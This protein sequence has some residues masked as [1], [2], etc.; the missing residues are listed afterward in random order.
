MFNNAFLRI[1]IGFPIAAAI[2]YSLFIF[3]GHLI[4]ADFVKPE[5]DEARTIERITPEQGGDDVQTRSR[6]K[7]Q[8]M[9]SANKPPPPPKITASKSDV[10]LPSA[11][12]QGAAPAEL[13]FERVQSIDIVTVVII[14]RDAQPISKPLATYPSRAVENNMEGTCDVSFDVDVRGKPYNV[15]AVCTNNIFKREAERAVARSEF[16]PKIVRGQALERKN[17]VYPMEFNLQE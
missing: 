15:T 8:R 12:L 2:I 9:K 4:S 17:V 7:P 13:K 6:S 3:M 11:Q 16:A 14:D 5:I 1:F 10:D